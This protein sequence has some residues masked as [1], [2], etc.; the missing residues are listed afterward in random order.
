MSSNALWTHELNQA[1]LSSSEGVAIYGAGF[2]SAQFI[3]RCKQEYPSIRFLCVVDAD[4]N[5]HGTTLLG[6]PVITPEHLTKYDIKTCIV[7][8]PY[9]YNFAIT[10][11][12]NSLGFFNLVYYSAFN[13]L[14]LDIAAR[15][16][17]YINENHKALELLLQ[18]NADKIAAVRKYLSHDDKSIAVFEAKL[19]SSYK[20]LHIAL[21]ALQE[22]E[23]YFPAGIINMTKEEI[24]VDCGAYDGATVLDFVKRVSMYNYIYALEPDPWQYEVVQWTLMEYNCLKSCEI[25]SIGAYDFDGYLSFESLGEGSSRVSTEGEIKVPVKSLDSLLYDKPNRPT[26]IKMDIEGA[27]L[28]A[29]EGARKIIKRDRPK[30]AICVYHG[31]PNTDLWEIPYWIKTNFPEYKIYMRQHASFNETV[32]YAV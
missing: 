32:C 24:F 14:I 20:G 19:D 4:S 22:D 5:K 30:L 13:K 26:F 21:E 25:H 7:I 2:N 15:K 18:E 17:M 9:K 12:L 10:D 31:Q 11:T 28:N 23:Q 8:T 29:L 6:V 1:V 27:E 3:I 16:D